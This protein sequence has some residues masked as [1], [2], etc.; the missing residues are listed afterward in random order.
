MQQWGRILVLSGKELDFPSTVVSLSL[1]DRR[2]SFYTFPEMDLIK[3]DS[4]IKNVISMCLDE[5]APQ[6][7]SS[8]QQQ[9]PSIELCVLKNASMATYQ[10]RDKVTYRRVR[11]CSI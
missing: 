10:V 6:P 9:V 8:R 2:I 11:P 4:P 1:S 5:R 7:L 3:T